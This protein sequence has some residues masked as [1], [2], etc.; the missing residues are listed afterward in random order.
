MNIFKL[1]S[2]DVRGLLVERPFITGEVFTQTNDS[3]DLG[4]NYLIDAATGAQITNLYAGDIYG[5]T[6]EYFDGTIAHPR[7]WQ[8]GSG[9][10]LKFANKFITT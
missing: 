6:G 2:G 10:A 9:N 3:N 4:E 8:L 7:V 5:G 1:A